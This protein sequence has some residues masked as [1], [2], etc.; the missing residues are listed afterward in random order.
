MTGD[1]TYP[2]GGVRLH[3]EGPL[4]KEMRITPSPEQAHYL[5][6]VMRAKAGDML[7]LFNGIPALRAHASGTGDA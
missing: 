1:L 4:R 5:L 3:V 7:S 6:H 2:G